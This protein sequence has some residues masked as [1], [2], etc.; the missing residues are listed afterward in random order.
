MADYFAS[1]LRRH[2]FSSYIKS[3]LAADFACALADGLHAMLA[4]AELV[5]VQ[6]TVPDGLLTAADMKHLR[7][8]AECA[9]DW[10]TDGHD[11]PKE[12][13][14]RLERLGAVRSLGFGRHETTA[15]GDA[16]LAAAPEAP[17]PD[18]PVQWWLA[19][20]DQY[21]N[22]T[23]IDGAHGQRAGA[24]QAFYLHSAL[25]LAGSGKYA[26]A[27]VEL[28]E[29]VADGSNVNH[30]AVST[31]RMAMQHNAAAPEAPQTIQCNA[32]NWIGSSADALYLGGR[33][34]IGP[35]CPECHETTGPAD[36]AAT[37]EA[38]EPVLD[39][40]ASIGGATVG[41]GIPVRTLVAAAQ[42]RYEVEQT[43][44]SLADRQALIDALRRP[45]V[46]TEIATLR[47]Q[48]AALVAALEGVLRWIDHWAQTGP[49]MDFER[50][51]AAADAA[52]SSTKGGAA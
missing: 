37:P 11:V 24:D 19:E 35:L 13:M 14:K 9:E 33:E 43:P 30:D 27:R 48:N 26:V 46:D 44:A 49:G 10:D 3:R 8:F 16:M 40:P 4:A 2:D 25:G 15:F 18:R 45:I 22:P 38:P 5:A 20:L 21:G 51:E 41:V 28:S 47:E 50:V 52:L 31:L 34:P 42:R 12:A 32:C 6:P 17:E 39:R 23:L 29:P 36:D 7:R 1:G